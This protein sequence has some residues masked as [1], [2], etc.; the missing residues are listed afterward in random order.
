[1]RG[2]RREGGG[3]GE[4]SRL[5][6]PPQ[7]NIH[8]GRSSQLK[9]PRSRGRIAIEETF[10]MEKRLEK[11]KGGKCGEEKYFRNDVDPVVSHSPAKA[12]VCMRVQTGNKQLLFSA[13]IRV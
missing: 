12:T 8:E 11:V 6:R 13:T 9:A 7:V 3:E 1:M 10:A 5:I 4:R 2:E